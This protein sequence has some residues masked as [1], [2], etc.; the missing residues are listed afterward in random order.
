M[1][2]LIAI[3]KNKRVQLAFRSP[4]LGI[5]V[6]TSIVPCI[7]VELKDK[8]IYVEIVDCIETKIIRDEYWS[9]CR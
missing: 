1:M 3:S 2:A 8:P 5:P 9:P 7:T 4:L 6:D